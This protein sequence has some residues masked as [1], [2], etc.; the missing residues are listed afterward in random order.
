MD[1]GF[2]R[3]P[4]GVFDKEYWIHP[5]REVD[6]IR[7]RVENTGKWMYSG[8]ATLVGA[9]GKT[10]MAVAYIK[11]WPYYRHRLFALA[12][13]GSDDAPEKFRGGVK[14]PVLHLD[15]REEDKRPNDADVC[16]GTAKENR[17]DPNNKKRKPQASGHPVLLTSDTTTEP[18]KFGR[19]KAAAAF[20]G[21]N[22]GNLRRYLNRKK[23]TRMRMPKCDRAG[24]WDAVYDEFRLDDAVRIVRAAA[25]LYLSPTRPNELFRKLQ[26]GKFA[27]TELERTDNGY[28]RLPVEGGKKEYLHRLVVYTLDPGAFA[29]KLAKNP[30]LKESDLQ[31]DHVDGDVGNNAIGNLEVLTARE[32]ARKHA[33]AI[34]WLDERG[35]VIQLFECAADVVEAVRGTEGQ[36]LHNAAVGRV[37]DGDRKHTGGRFFR[38]ADKD[39]VD[40][41]RTAKKTKRC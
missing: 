34:E 38:W 32:H 8:K 9:E 10:K 37:C 19:A 35:N 15:R 14:H 11:G 12:S 36:R 26:T 7:T 20:L 18:V 33:L 6:W 4:E 1:E 31:V 24:V 27:T 39:G 23:P 29:T 25:E 17:T 3:I 28:F 21:T 13:D 16:F 40:A 2:L 41:K 5:T 30:G 22:H